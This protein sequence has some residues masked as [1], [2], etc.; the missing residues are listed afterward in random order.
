M[1]LEEFLLQHSGERKGDC[2]LFS[3][4]VGVNGCCLFW[5]E[6][7][8]QYAHRVV[9]RL[10]LGREIKEGHY[11]C[12]TC[13]VRNCI[14]PEHLWEGTPQE[15]QDDAKMKARPGYHDHKNGIFLCGHEMHPLNIIWKG[16]K[17]YCRVCRDKYYR[18]W[19]K[20][21]EMK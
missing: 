2:I 20:K 10:K 19:K 21:N 16:R 12:H 1:S 7:K 9:L 3:G 11:A 8:A 15:N 6:G 5:F 18:E 13:D 4:H 17:K 14:N